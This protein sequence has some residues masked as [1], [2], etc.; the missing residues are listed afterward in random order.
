M[1]EDLIK[2]SDAIEAVKRV[3]ENYTGKGKRDYHPHVDFIVDE[4]KYCVPSADRPQ[5][6]WIEF[7]TKWGRSFYYCTNCMETSEVPTAFGQPLYNFCPNCGARMKGA[8]DEH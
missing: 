3:S 5:G 7:D 2:R 8:Y 4:L 6:E 1:S